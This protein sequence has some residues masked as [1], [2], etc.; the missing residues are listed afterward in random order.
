MGTRNQTPNSERKQQGTQ[1]SSK[2][3]QSTHKSTGGA[4]AKDSGNVPRS[5][6][7]LQEEAN[8]GTR[9]NGAD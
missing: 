1:K 4:E 2:Q 3:R 9:V 6:D 5:D 8:E 7:D